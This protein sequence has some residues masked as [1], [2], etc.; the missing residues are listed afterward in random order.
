ML[1]YV[2]A[3]CSVALLVA[4]KFAVHLNEA[5]VNQEIKIGCTMLTIFPFF[6]QMGLGQQG[7]G[8]TQI[9]DAVFHLMQEKTN[10]ATGGHGR[11]AAAWKTRETACRSGVWRTQTRRR[12]PST[13]QG[14]FSHSR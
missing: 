4:Q 14:P 2:D 6:P 12:A 11:A 13:H 5:K 3:L 1:L 8:N 9:S 7:G 10:V